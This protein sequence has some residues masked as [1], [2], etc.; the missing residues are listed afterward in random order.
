[1]K[2]SYDI[3]S[4]HRLQGGSSDWNLALDRMGSSTLAG[5]KMALLEG[6]ACT[7]DLALLI[8]Y[9]DYSISEECKVRTQDKVGRIRE[10]RNNL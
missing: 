6:L 8:A 10:L 9:L 2:Y 7:N 1:M 5:E 3:Q 4:H